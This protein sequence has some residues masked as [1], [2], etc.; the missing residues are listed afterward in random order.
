MATSCGVPFCHTPR[1]RLSIISLSAFL[2]LILT[3]FLALSIST[4]KQP[5]SSGA[6]RLDDFK[7]TQVRETLSKQLT[8]DSLQQEGFDEMNQLVIGD[9]LQQEEEEESF[10]KETLA[11]ELAGDALHHESFKG[12]TL[13]DGNNVQQDIRLPSTDTSSHSH[14]R[15]T[16]TTIAKRRR[17]PQA[18][19]IGVRKG[20]TRALINMLKCHPDIVA[21]LEEIH[22]YDRDENF[23]RGV[24]WYVEQMPTST[25]HQ[26]TI[27]KSPYYFV[28]PTTPKRIHEISPKIKIILIVRNPIDRAV[29]DY[30]Q[31]TRKRSNRGSFE[32]FIFQAPSGSGQVNTGCSPVS[33]SCY[34]VHFKRW[35]RY[36]DLD[37]IHIVDGDALISNPALEVKRVESFLGV[38]SYFTEDMFYFNATKGFYCWTKLDKRKKV[39]PD[40]LG[41]EKGHTMPQLNNQT[42]QR[43]ANFFK[44]HNERFF[45]QIRRRFNWDTKYR[46]TVY[47]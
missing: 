32:D 21:A 29:S 9:A 12:E 33:A 46:N 10:E 25:E 39:I 31:L 47:T 1:G 43:L 34:N 41:S 38:S 4:T 20:G 42:V 22:F 16:N 45:L 44:P 37:Q 15:P 36:F 35:L 7:N 2:A 6:V 26:I 14:P 11:K 23:K 18:L 3:Y 27:E 40:C 30:N 28:S 13:A 8:G 17:Y 5:T 19:I 24:R